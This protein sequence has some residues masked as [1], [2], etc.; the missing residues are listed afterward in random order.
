MTRHETVLG[1]VVLTI[2]AVGA[3]CGGTCRR[4]EKDRR[5]FLE[6]T[7]AAAEPHVEISVPFTVAEGL[8]NGRIGEIDPLPLKL[9]IP[10][11]LAD[12][13]GR[14]EVRPRGVRLLPAAAGRLAFRL[15]FDVADRDRDRKLF[16]ISVDVEVEPL[17]DLEAGRVEI[18]ITAESLGKIKPTISKDAKR[19]LGGMVWD[20]IPKAAR[21]LLPRKFVDETAGS[22]VKSL[23]SGFYERSKD[24]LLKRLGDLSRISLQLPDVPLRSLTIES[25]PHG[26]LRLLVVTGLPVRTGL[27]KGAPAPADR[28]AVRLSGPAMA[29]LTNWAMASGLLPD[30]YDDKGKA[31]ADGEL[32]PGLDWVS[33]KRPMKVFLWDLDDTC[34]RLT[35]EATPELGVKDGKVAI[36]ARDAE[37]T[38][39]EASAFVKAGV[40]FHLLWKDAFDVSK[41][42][43]AS[44]KIEVAGQELEVG[45]ATAE[46]VDDEIILGLDVVTK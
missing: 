45:V 5:A 44:A 46:L 34:M 22:V 32:R 17:V 40:W 26:T 41:K 35:L 3:G 6:R 20:R 1:I 13:F 39:I 10:A 4:I 15:L 30:R 43:K 31:K 7:A 9:S 42:T 38:D 2:A 21:L 14:L 16:E 25:D 8:I 19:E 12:Y 24:K 28:I 27:K 29:E 36:G 18:E 37:V 33:G 11:V 23:V